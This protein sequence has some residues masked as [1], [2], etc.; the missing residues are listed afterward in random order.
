MVP[1]KS[2]GSYSST[3]CK[4]LDLTNKTRRHCNRVYQTD[5]TEAAEKIKEGTCGSM[6]IALRSCDSPS[7]EIS[8]P[9]MVIEPD[10]S[11]STRNR[12]SISDDLPEPVRPHLSNRHAHHTDTQCAS[13][14]H[15]RTHAR[16]HAH[17]HRVGPNEA[18]AFRNLSM[19]ISMYR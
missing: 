2:V 17:T 13:H 10:A 11:S 7:L 6:A 5:R 16:T 19:H 9:S 15:A 1:L 14:T 18:M 8:I 4:R 3:Q 12:V